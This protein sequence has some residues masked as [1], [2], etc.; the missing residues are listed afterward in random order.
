VAKVNCYGSMVDLYDFSYGAS[1]VTVLGIDVADPKAA[2]RTQAGYASLTFA[3]WPDA[4][5]VF[6]TEVQFGTGWI[7]YVGSYPP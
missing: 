7:D 1:K 2:A 5:R 4:G 6:F 3:P